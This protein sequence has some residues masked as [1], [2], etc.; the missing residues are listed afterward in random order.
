MNQALAAAI[1]GARSSEVGSRAARIGYGNRFR[2][3]INFFGLQVEQ[4]QRAVF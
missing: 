3:R 1:D 2:N 4:L